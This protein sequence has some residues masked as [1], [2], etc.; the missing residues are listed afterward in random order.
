[1][2]PPRPIRALI[3][4]SVIGL[5]TSGCETR[6]VDPTPPQL[7]RLQ[8]FL[9]VT[10][11]EQPLV[12]GVILDLHLPDSGE[13]AR[14]RDR[15]LATVRSTMASAAPQLAELAMIDLS[16]GCQQPSDRR[17]DFA[18]YNS[19][20]TSAQNRF[21]RKPVRPLLLYFNN[22][23]LPLG[24]GLLN[25]F[26]RF[27]VEAFLKGQPLPLIWGTAMPRTLQSGVAFDA[28][29]PWTFTTDPSLFDGIAET[30]SRQLPLRVANATPPEGTPL[31]STEEQGW[32]LEFKLCGTQP[33]I[34][35]VNFDLSG[36]AVVLQPSAPPRV[37][38]ALPEGPVLRTEVEAERITFT[39]EACRQDCG[40][41]YPTRSGSVV[42]NE[43]YGCLLEAP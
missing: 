28:T 23:D 35:G 3:T 27:R 2:I 17:I 13:C 15:L 11:T 38:L 39:I 18:A 20:L 26:E 8:K 25:D 41:L 10:V 33:R 31:F 40:R 37:K 24:T 36:E 6:F 42:W 7:V 43:T 4:L 34:T 14:A 22:I 16:P 32:V 9:D 19:E 21:P 29:F 30:A 12:F 1:M 5:G